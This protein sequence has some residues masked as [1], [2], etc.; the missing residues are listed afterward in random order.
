MSRIFA[1]KITNYNNDGPFEA[2]KGINIP[3]NRPLQVG[4]ILG[5]T[6]QYLASTGVG[7]EWKTLPTIFTGSWDDLTDKP[8]W[9]NTFSGSYAQLT[10]KPTIPPFVITNATGGQIFSF[11]GQNWTNVNP[12][13]IY[14]YTIEKT[15]ISPGSIKAYS[16]SGTATS[17]PASYR[18]TSETSGVVVSNLSGGLTPLGPWSFDI[19]KA[20]GTYT[21]SLDEAGSR[22][23]VGDT[24]GIPGNLLGGSSG[25]NNLTITITQVNPDNLFTIDVVNQLNEKTSIPIIGSLGVNIELNND[26]QISFS[27]DSEY[28]GYDPEQVKTDVATMISSGTSTGIEYTFRFIEDP[29]TGG[30]T[31][32]VMDSVVDLSNA[33]IYLND[34]TDVDINVNNLNNNDALI[35]DANTESWRNIP[36][37]LSSFDITT[38]ETPELEPNEIYDFTFEVNKKNISICQ[39]TNTQFEDLQFRTILY[40]NLPNRE[41]DRKRLNGILQAN[42]PDDVTS[43][44]YTGAFYDNKNNKLILLHHSNQTETTSTNSSIRYLTTYDFSNINT[45]VTTAVENTTKIYLPTSSASYLRSLTFDYTGQYAYAVTGTTTSTTTRNVYRWGLMNPTFDLADLSSNNGTL[46]SRSTGTLMTDAVDISISDNGMHD[47]FIIPNTIDNNTILNRIVANTEF[48]LTAGTALTST[49]SDDAMASFCFGGYNYQILNLETQYNLG[50]ILFYSTDDVFQVIGAGT[51]GQSIATIPTSGILE[52]GTLKAKKIH[53]SKCL[54][55]QVMYMIGSNTNTLYEYRSRMLF[56]KFGNT[57]T[58]SNP[59]PSSFYLTAKFELKDSDG[60]SIIVDSANSS[61]AVSSNGQNIFIANGTNL[62]YQYK[63]KT[64]WDITTI[65]QTNNI[66]PHNEGIIIDASIDENNISKEIDIVPGTI[67]NLS[68]INQT[69]TIHGSVVNKCS[70][71]KVLNFDIKYVTF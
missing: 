9:L 37:P 57:S 4:G 46:Y 8:S 38:I 40:K 59:T 13:Q 12:P 56:S 49:I 31:T 44:V 23:G 10:N 18:I 28:A 33:Q 21:V 51:S 54:R 19:G 47:Y 70:T 25:T 36:I 29:E 62:V 41:N 69:N 64:P 11:N 32:R 15:Y 42:L 34:V 5:N 53:L 63:L 27:I 24:I 55:G 48:Q 65:Y 30:F 26:D 60:R 61:I 2:E 3:E 68:A 14:Q 16:F 67:S 45:D 1:N 71:N 43:R 6:G 20:A 17:G 35:Y 52:T 50:D 58:S 66:A 7:L 22:F 39:I